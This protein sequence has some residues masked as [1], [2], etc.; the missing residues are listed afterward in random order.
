M[1]DA[2]RDSAAKPRSRHWMHSV[3]KRGDK[4]AEC[5]KRATLRC[6]ACNRNFCDECEA[7]AH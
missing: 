3:L 5:G 1:T 7:W 6:P 2:I 4:C